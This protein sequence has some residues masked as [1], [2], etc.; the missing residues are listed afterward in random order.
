MVGFASRF[1]KQGFQEASQDN[2][3]TPLFP[4]GQRGVFY[5]SPIG[6][7]PSALCTL[8]AFTALAP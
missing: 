2:A 5:S 3:A 7:A 1:V 6:V 8:L 4:R